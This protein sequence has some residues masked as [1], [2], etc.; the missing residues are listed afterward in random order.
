MADLVILGNSIHAAAMQV[1]EEP[2]GGGSNTRR[3]EGKW[4]VE[5]DRSPTDPVDRMV[6]NDRLER[7]ACRL[8]RSRGF[9]APWDPPL[10][11]IEE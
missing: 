11:E 6:I 7:A 2:D 10:T 1:A 3:L 8:A 4:K 5:V 9:R